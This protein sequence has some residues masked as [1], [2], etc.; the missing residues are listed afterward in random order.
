MSTSQPQFPS[1]LLLNLQPRQPLPIP[2]HLAEGEVLAVDG[3]INAEAETRARQGVMLNLRVLEIT[4]L[5]VRRAKAIDLGDVSGY[6]G[7]PRPTTDS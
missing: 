5:L 1:P 6:H 3:T 7:L 2:S 4:L